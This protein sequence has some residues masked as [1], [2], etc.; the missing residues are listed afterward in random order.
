MH[1]VD[2]AS[3]KNSHM[4]MRSASRA[5]VEGVMRR[6]CEEALRVLREHKDRWRPSSRCSSTTRS[7]AGRSP[8]PARSSVR[9]TM[10]TWR[11]VRCPCEPH[12]PM[13]DGLLNADA[14]RALLRIKQKLDGLEGGGSLLII[15]CT[16]ATGTDYQ[17]KQGMV[18]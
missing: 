9:K 5:G 10:P 12:S 8:P 2:L 13:E 11:R 7:T 1:P 6:C 14:E 18:A 4:P 3:I 17:A 16:W 15:F